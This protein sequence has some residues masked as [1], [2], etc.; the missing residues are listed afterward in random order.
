MRALLAPISLFVLSALLPAQT[1]RRSGASPI[2]LGLSVGVAE[3]EIGMSE[4][5]TRRRLGAHYTIKEFASHPGHLQIERAGEPFSEGYPTLGALEIEGGKVV[6]ILAKFAEERFEAD[7]YVLL[8]ERAFAE[9]QSRVS[10]SSCQVIH[11][12]IPGMRDVH[13]RH[14]CGRYTLTVSLSG[15]EKNSPKVTVSLS[16]R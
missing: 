10:L 1:A 3:L 4:Q 5:E 9:L 12:R 2:T 15:D 7:D 11:D 14:R 13:L 6:A 16:V 8:L